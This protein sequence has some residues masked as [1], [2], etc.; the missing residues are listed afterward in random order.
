MI[1]LFLLVPIFLFA[2]TLDPL[3]LEKALS[4]SY[5]FLGSGG[6]CTAYV[7]ADGTYVLKLFKNR[8][9]PLS[10]ESRF[11]PFYTRWH[12]LRKMQKQMDKRDRLY[13]AYRYCC[14]KLSEE[15][16]ILY[17]H[18]HTDVD[19]DT[20]DF[21]LQKRAIGLEDY[22]LTLRAQGR[23]SDA[24]KAVDQLLELPYSLYKKGMRDRDTHF[25]NN[26]G[27][28]EDKPVCFDVGRF[29]PIDGEEKKKSYEKKRAL[30]KKTLY[31][32]LKI[33]YPEL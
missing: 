16:G 8:P 25:F 10:K 30:F 14:D 26:Y 7:S 9:F 27:F 24:R 13:F 19:L 22:F 3:S 29:V 11:T 31:D 28:I 5:Q 20:C 1:F 32:W 2:Q 4:Q 33:H 15:T 17:V 6:Q 12:R 18:F 21:V 23:L